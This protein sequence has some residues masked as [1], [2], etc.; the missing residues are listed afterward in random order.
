M[1]VPDLV[2]LSHLPWDFVYQRPNH[3]MARAA[4]ERRVFFIEEPQWSGERAFVRRTRRDE[5]TIVRPL[6]PAAAR[7]RQAY[8]L[9]QDAISAFLEREGVV[10]PWLWYYTPMALMWMARVRASA[11]IYD[12]MDELSAFRSAP[13][14]LRDLERQ[15]LRGADVV[16]TGGRSLYEAKRAQHAHTHLFPSSVDRAHFARARDVLPEPADQAAISRPRIGYFGVID[17][18]LDLELIAHVAA[19]RPGWQIVMVGP[20]AKIDED[21]LPR[22]SNLHWLG[23][24]E[25]AQLPAYLSGWDVAIMPFA[26]NEAT[27][28]ISPTKTPEYLSGGRPVVSTPVRDVV[29]PYGE[30]GVVAIA[31][32]GPAFVRA[33]QAALATDRRTLWARADALL[34]AQSW[35]ATWCAMRDLV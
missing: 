11:V 2:C 12:C 34:A 28:Y 14:R 24:K 13:A 25:Y 4:R 30:Q 17:E 21:D 8:L 10:D 1:S 19:A 20:T 5:L 3:L 31:A 32:D 29:R 16:F 35:D 15:L 23:L 7:G 22:A 33:I 9:L 18:R 26:L 6:V 27:R